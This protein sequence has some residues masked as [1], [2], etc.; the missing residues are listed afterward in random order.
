MGG[1][2]AGPRGLLPLLAASPVVALPLAVLPAAL[3][4]PA[5]LVRQAFAFPTGRADVPTPARSRCPAA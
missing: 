5:E 3:P 1:P 4:Q 2:D